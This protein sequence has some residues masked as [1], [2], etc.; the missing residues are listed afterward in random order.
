[1]VVLGSLV[2]LSV[3]CAL[4]AFWCLV[5]PNR[6]MQRLREINPEQD[7]RSEWATTL[8]AIASPLSKLTVPDGDWETS[9][10]RQQF[11]HAG[12]RDSR[13]PTIYFGL[14][15][16]LPLALAAAVFIVAGPFVKS[17]LTLL[18]YV[19]IGALVGCYLPNLVLRWLVKS[20]QREVFESF[21]DAADLLLVCVEAGLGL[22][23]ALTKVAEEIKHKSEAIAE[24]LHLANLEMRAGAGREKTLRNLAARTGLDELGTFAAMLIQADRF[25]TNIGDALRVF[26]DDLRHKR[27]VRAEELAAKAPTK[28]LFPL[29][30]CIFP[31]VIMVILGPAVIRIIRSLAPMLGAS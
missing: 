7:K 6:T 16:V 17:Q 14:K 15:A 3:A 23:A 25:G 20:R 5:A 9:P 30:A 4:V 19:L 18:L 1:M 2:F 22:D 11:M 8:V 21:P 24:E 31:A 26:S 27:Q 29:V 13:A 12:I 10:T 28:M